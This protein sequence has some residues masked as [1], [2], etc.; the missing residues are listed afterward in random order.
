MHNRSNNVK[1]TG[2][3]SEI[4]GTE[5]TQTLSSVA[6]S[7]GV[8]NAGSFHKIVNGRPISTTNPG[9]VRIFGSADDFDVTIQ[10]IGAIPGTDGG[11]EAWNN[12]SEFVP[13]EIIAYSAISDDGQ[14]ITV[15]PSGRGSGGTAALEW[16]TGTTVDCYNLDGIP[17]TEVNKTHTAIQDPTL[18]SYSIVTTSVASIGI[19]TG[20][21]GVQ[22]TK[23]VP[24]ELITPTIQI[25]N[26]KETSISPSLN[27]TS[28][29]SIGNGSTI[30]DQASFINNGV[31]DEIQLNEENYYETPRI[32]A[33]Q[34]N[35]DNKLE[36]SKSLTMKVNMTSSTDNL[37]PV[38]DLDRV[39]VITTS[40]RINSWEGGP[41]VLGLQSEINP[42]GDVSTLPYGDQND[43]VYLTRV[44]RLANVSRSIRLMISMQRYGDSNIDVYYRIQKP[45]SEKQMNDIGFSKIPVPE[46]GATNVS[47]AEWEDFEYT[48]EGEEFQAFQM[49]IVMKSKNQAKVPLIKDLRAIAFAS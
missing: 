22:A 45:G 11:T 21:Y 41:Q 38:I 37:S 1:I 32:I 44:A 34:L 29:T 36:G 15:A 40:N 13:N 24:Y 2:V 48:V 9:Y 49:K 17:L 42:Q 23:N 7:I 46:V 18:D 8:S 33:S 47:E 43:A 35:E 39:S 28:G 5:L 19:R 6:T 12:I 10:P 26:F 4:P 31:Y 14:T 20:G 3:S 27:T 25:M 30:A 16:A